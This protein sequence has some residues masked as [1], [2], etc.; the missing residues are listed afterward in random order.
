MIE[1]DMK[2]AFRGAM[3]RLAGGVAIVTAAEEGRRYGMTMTAVMSLSMDPP[4]LAIGVNR[5]ASIAAPLA[6]T[7]RFCVNLLRASHDRFCA[8]FSALATDER[9]TVGDWHTDENGLPWLADAQ[10]VMFCTAG[11][12]T[13]FGTHDLI[14]GLVDRAINEPAIAPLLHLDGSYM[15][16]AP[17]ANV[18]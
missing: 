4:S 16:A 1:D 3:R 15:A 8:D 9:F 11:P 13:T 12:V 5:S 6:R 10:A 18:S 14:V 17:L 7:G 2:E